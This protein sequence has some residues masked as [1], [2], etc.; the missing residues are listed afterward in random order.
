[1]LSL[2]TKASE[3][4]ITWRKSGDAA[5]IADETDEAEVCF[6]QGRAWKVTVETLRQALRVIVTGHPRDR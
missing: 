4:E 6:D 5:L 2:L 1:M 3:Q